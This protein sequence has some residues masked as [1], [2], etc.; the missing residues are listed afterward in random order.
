[1]SL[2]VQGA[3]RV[4]RQRGRADVVAL[5]GVDLEVGDDEVLVLV[6]HSGSGKTTLLRAV[7]GLESLDGGRVLLGG[8]D[9]MSVAPRGRGVA[10]VFQEAALFPHLRVRDN[11][12]VGER[13]RGADRASIGARVEAVAETLDV[14]HLLDRMPSALSGGER[15]RVA[16]AR[17]MI[18]SPRVL[19]LDEPLA[20]V[21]AEQRVRMRAVIRDVQRRLGVPMVYVTHD[22]GE[23]MALGDRVAFIEG[24]R[25]LQCATPEELYARPAT[26]GVARGFGPLP[27]NLS[28]ARN[29]V[30]TGVRPE[31]VRLVTADTVGEDRR[32]DGDSPAAA[33]ALAGAGAGTLATVAAREPSGEE[34]LVHLVS[35]DDERWVARVPASEAFTAGDRVRVSWS[36]DDEHRFDAETGTR[37]A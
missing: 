15:Q 3:R 2:R 9:V 12:G 4:F 10:L 8:E 29:G 20:A 31:R 14:A 21:D 13:A 35:A 33:E 19:L 36:P 24:G 25:L 22:Q 17:A 18:R 5:D 16:L 23:A 28:A 27:M 11:I 6:G 26:V 34:S 30:V 37:L 7:A 32:G 1:M